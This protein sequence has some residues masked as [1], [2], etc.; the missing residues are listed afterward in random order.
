MEAVYGIDKDEKKPHDRERV[1]SASQ[2]NICYEAP[3]NDYV[4]TSSVQP[5]HASPRR[6]SSKSIHQSSD[7]ILSNTQINLCYEAPGN[8]DIIVSRPSRLDF[9]RKQDDMVT[10]FQISKSGL[11]TSRPGFTAVSQESP[12]DITNEYSV[13]GT[14]YTTPDEPIYAVPGSLEYE[15]S[16][17]HALS[18]RYSAEGAYDNDYATLRGMPHVQDYTNADDVI[19]QSSRNV[20]KVKSD[21]MKR[22]KKT[23]KKKDKGKKTEEE[24]VYENDDTMMVY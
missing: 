14:P 24:N 3:N 9:I 2:M 21:E 19:T 6:I 15:S 11:V 17:D 23:E 12:K 20:K 18:Q 8:D 7:N 4:I 22:N 1:S 13:V 10:S 16:F 5:K